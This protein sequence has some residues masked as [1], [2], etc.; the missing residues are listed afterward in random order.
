MAEQF[1]ALGLQGV[2]YAVDNY[3]KVRQTQCPATLILLIAL[4]RHGI[5]SSK[6]PRRSRNPSSEVVGVPIR[7][8]MTETARMGRAVR[9]ARINTAKMATMPRVDMSR[10][11]RVMI[12]T[13]R[14]GDALLSVHG[15]EQEADPERFRGIT[16]RSHHRRDADEIHHELR[17]RTIQPSHLLRHEEIGT[18]VLERRRSK[19]A[20]CI[21]MRTDIG[22]M[23][24]ARSRLES[25][26]SVAKR[27]DH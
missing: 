13:N 20:N 24:A 4:S 21:S 18:E 19:T 15:T 23:T 7:M 1:V 10:M 9:T 22:R 12:R 27:T 25:S 2:P 5:R 8:V 26:S 16:Q 17:Q 6:V 11:T 14:R 3:H